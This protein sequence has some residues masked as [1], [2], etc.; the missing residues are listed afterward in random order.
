MATLTK[1]EREYIEYTLKELYDA[2][3][4]HA[5]MAYKHREAGEIEKAARFS[6]MY[7]KDGERISG[8]ATVLNVVGYTYTWDADDNV[9]LLKT[10]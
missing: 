8:I 5:D 10:K 9:H 7:E 6:R 1:K 4:R 3:E 2:E